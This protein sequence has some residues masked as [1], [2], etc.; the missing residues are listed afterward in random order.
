MLGLPIW[1]E[2]Y[3]NI[4]TDHGPCM[5][6]MIISHKLSPTV[7]LKKAMSFFFFFCCSKDF[8]VEEMKAIKFWDKA[9]EES[10]GY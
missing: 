5:I 3:L 6:D 4:V 8:V 10:C 9:L 7:A 2:E 1:Y